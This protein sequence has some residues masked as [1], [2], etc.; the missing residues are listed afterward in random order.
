MSTAN[1]EM[2]K[3]CF[4]VHQ[5]QPLDVTVPTPGSTSSPSIKNPSLRHQ[6][7]LRK[8]CK[9]LNTV[10]LAPSPKG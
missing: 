7:L 6:V 5:Y 4:S 3:V 1:S 2:T 10:D 9:R 8:C